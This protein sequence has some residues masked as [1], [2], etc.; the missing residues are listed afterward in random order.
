MILACVA[1]QTMKLILSWDYLFQS[2][3]DRNLN[4]TK[5]DHQDQHNE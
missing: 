4:D 1:T 3:P 2:D 5:Q